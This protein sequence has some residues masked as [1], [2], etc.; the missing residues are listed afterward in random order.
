MEEGYRPDRKTCTSHANEVV[1]AELARASTTIK[2][3]AVVPFSEDG[4]GNRWQDGFSNKVR[5]FRM[6]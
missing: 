5:T 1:T 4:H 3:D 2:G 6:N